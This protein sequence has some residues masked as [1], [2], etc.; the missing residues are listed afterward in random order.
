MQFSFDPKLIDIA[1]KVED[2]ERL[3]L[4][5]GVALYN[6][7]DLNALGKLAD[8]FVT[9]IVPFYAL[10]VASIFVFRRRAGYNPPFRTPLYPV[11]PAMF[12]LATCFLLGN[13]IIDPT[14][15]WPTLAV[16]GIILVGIPVYYLTVGRSARSAASPA[17]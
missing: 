8:T 2:S 7:T 12:I 10:A 17:R 3:T 6:T 9:A 16:M 15:R 4:E 1:F 14:S 11:V 13:A 5:E